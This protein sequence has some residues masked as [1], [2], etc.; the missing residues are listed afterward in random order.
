M[1]QMT[2]GDVAIVW[3]FFV[4]LVALAVIVQTIWRSLWRV[5]VLARRIR[6][7]WDGLWRGIAESVR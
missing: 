2:L 3:L 7:G 5:R 1:P 6:N 4:V